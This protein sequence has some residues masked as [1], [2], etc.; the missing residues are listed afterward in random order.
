MELKRQSLGVFVAL[1]IGKIT[2][3]N[4]QQLVTT[5]IC[6]QQNICILGN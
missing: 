5:N 2:S 1:K 6:L 4:C 3:I